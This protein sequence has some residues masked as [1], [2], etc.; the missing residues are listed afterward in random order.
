MRSFLDT[1][2]ANTFFQSVASL[3]ISVT[4]SLE[5]F[6]LGDMAIQSHDFLSVGQMLL[7]L[8]AVKA[9]AFVGQLSPLSPTSSPDR[10]WVA[11]RD[12]CALMPTLVHSIHKG[13]QSDT[14]LPGGNP[15]SATPGPRPGGSEASLPAS[16]PRLFR[17]GIEGSASEGH[18]AYPAPT[19]HK[20]CASSDLSGSL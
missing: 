13:Q 9:W 19:L 12:S 6:N 8:R 5:G 17:G 15:G 7:C 11:D 18:A 3:L 4:V 20:A 2:F 14:R 16:A 1:L 10:P